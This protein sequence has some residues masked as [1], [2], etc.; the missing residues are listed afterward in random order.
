MGIFLTIVGGLLFIYFNIKCHVKINISYTF[1]HVNI[2]VIFLKKKYVY[3]KIYNYLV[4][5]KIIRKYR[6]SEVRHIYK[7]RRKYFKYFKKVFRIFYVKNILL[8]PECLLGKQ[9]F[10]FE[11]AVVNV[12]LKKSL[13][14][15]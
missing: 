14:N 9:S 1:L 8:Y 13:L 2:Y 5:E 10:A 7:N 15:G 3:E 4:A 11:F 12:V 6:K